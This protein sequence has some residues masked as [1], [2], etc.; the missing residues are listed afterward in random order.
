MPFASS[1]RP[2]LGVSLLKAHLN[3]DGS[4]CDVAYLDLDFAETIGREAYERIVDGLP[5]RA[6]AGE[7][8]FAECLW[9]SDGALPVSY[10][11]DVLRT[12]WRVGQDDIDVVRRARDLASG[13]LKSSLAT[14]PWADYDVV[15]FSAFAAQN[16]A[17]LALARLVKQRQPGIVVVF[18]GANWQG[19][20]GLRLHQESSFV[21]LAC[22]GEADISFP[23]LVR[24]LAGDQAVRLDQVPGLIYRHAGTSRANP[25]GE[26]LADLDGLPLPDYSDF[27]AA[28][29]GHAGVRSALPSLTVE[30]SR[31]CWWARTGPCSFCGMDSRERRY[32]AKSA[33]RVLAELRELTAR[34]PCRVI[35]LA[36][37]VVPP[38]FLDEVLPAVAADPLP[39]RLFFEVRPELT[40]AQIETIAAARAEIQ[41]GIESFS[42]H[43]LRLMHKGTRALEN[44]RLLNGA[45]RPGSGCTG[46]SCT[47]CPG[48]RLATTRPCWRSCPR[49]ASSPPRPARP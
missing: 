7:W 18:G 28:R 48:R 14:V 21:D 9:G 30:T 39:A 22:S 29:H 10:V 17:S 16:L 34:W 13:F 32:R 25:E 37:T 38:A 24:R 45:G 49:C 26:P 15:G 41:P 27:Y 40:K 36:D 44:I 1:E 35:H 42:D 5:V 8:V 19:R 3:R 33:G 43:V 46:T 23:L 31:G 20:P 47:A 2:A 4:A 11:D 12:R 6:L